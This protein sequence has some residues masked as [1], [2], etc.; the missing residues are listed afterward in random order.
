MSKYKPIKIFHIYYGYGYWWGR[1]FF[2]IGK[3]SVQFAIVL[4]AMEHLKAIYAN[5]G[6]N[7]WHG[8]V[9]SWSESRQH[10]NNC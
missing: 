6:H 8:D 7:I 2:F 5:N 10:E 3:H 9:L 4:M 1:Y